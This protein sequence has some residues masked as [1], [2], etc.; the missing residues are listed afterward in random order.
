MSSEGS[1][2][3]T[4]EDLVPIK[5]LVGG[6]PLVPVVPARTS[7]SAEAYGQFNPK[8]NFKPKMV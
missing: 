6:K 4:V 7:V 2:S 1:D 8:S 3:E 5:K